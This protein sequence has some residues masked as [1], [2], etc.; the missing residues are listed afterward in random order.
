MPTALPSRY[1]DRMSSPAD[2][3]TRFVPLPENR[4]ALRAIA[5]LAEAVVRDVD[6]PLHF[7]H[8]PPGC[9]KSLLV[10]GLIERVTLGESARTAQ[11]AAAAEFGRALLQAPL[12][13]S[14]AAREALDCDLLVVEDAQH[15]PLA[16]SDE[17]GSILDRRLARRKTVVVTASRSPAELNCSARL[18]GRFAGGLAIA[19]QPL[20]EPSR[21]ELAAALCRERKLQVADDVLAWLARDPGGARPILGDVTRLV[22]LAKVCKPPLTLAKVRNEMPEPTAGQPPMARIVELVAA[23]CQLPPK[24]LTGPSRVANVAHARHL[25]MYLARQAGLT[26]VEI[27]HNLGGRDHTTV[28]HAC[29]KIEA[30][31]AADPRLAQ[32]VRDLRSELL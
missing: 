23:R 10:A 26:L 1:T 25:A 28:M 29:G 5:Q 24:A 11:T 27:G 3:L 31:I 12:E 13:R 8:G 16:A 32:Q 4:A 19:I 17:L 7:L 30:A 20:C 18:A 22:Q 14:A 15:L 9:G 6:S 2:A 21:R